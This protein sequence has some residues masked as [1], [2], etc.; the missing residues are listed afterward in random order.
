MNRTLASASLGVFLSAWLAAPAAGQQAAAPPDQVAPAPPGAQSMP[1]PKIKVGTRKGGWQIDVHGGFLPGSNSTAGTGS[2]PPRGEGFT[3][4]S[5]QPSRFVPSYYF[6]DG[7]ALLNTVLSS[8]NMTQA[9][10]ASLDG[11]LTTG[12]ARQTGPAFGFRIGHSVTSHALAEFSFDV[13]HNQVTLSDETLAAIEA[14]R[15]SFQAVFDGILINTAANAKT[16][17]TAT[18]QNGSG[19]QMTMIGSVSIN[20]PTFGRFTPYVTAGGGLMMS[21][22]TQTGFTMDGRYSFTLNNPSSAANGA[23]FGDTNSF[24]AFYGVPSAIVKLFGGG[25]NMRLSPRSGVRADVRAY[26]AGM[27]V[28]V[29]TDNTIPTGSAIGSVTRGSNGPQV[30][31]SAGSAPSTLENGGYRYTTFTGSGKIV[32]VTFAYF[33]RF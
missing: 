8:N 24:A 7:A 6:G 1:L 30:Q 18:L 2:L 14:A 31:F 11:V 26:L 22:G 21:R 28:D 10:M 25:V 32:T 4:S 15:A 13:G 23:S 27:I 12:A 9:R 29:V 16:T 19:S 5:N 33:L 17:S 20:L 3:T